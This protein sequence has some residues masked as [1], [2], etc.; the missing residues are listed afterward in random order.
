MK[1]LSMILLIGIIIYSIKIP[2]SIAFENNNKIESIVVAG[3]CFWCIEHDM[4]QIKG[5][6]DVISGY[7]GG[8]KETANYKTVSTGTTGHREVIQIKYNPK[9]ISFEEV[10]RKFFVLVNPLDAGGQFCDRGYQYTTAIYYN[11]KSEEEISKNIIEEI[12]QTNLLPGKIQTKIEKFKGFWP[13]E[14]YHQD[15]A[16]KNKL[17]YNYYRYSCGRDRVVQSVWKNYNQIEGSE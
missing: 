1:K 5:I 13:A 15:Y 11:N 14:E 16:Q 4:E 2:A 8:T 12:D 7:A 9:E 17:R 10:I 3:G 6:E